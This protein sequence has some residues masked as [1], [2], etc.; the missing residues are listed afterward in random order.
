MLQKNRRDYGKPAFVLALLCV[1]LISLREVRMVGSASA[2][3]RGNV[4]R[5]VVEAR[6]FIVLDGAGRRVAVLGQ[7]A[8]PGF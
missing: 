2:R 8:K 7:S 6:S 5:A 4:P 1:L 3:Q